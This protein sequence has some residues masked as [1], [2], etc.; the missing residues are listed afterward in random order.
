LK[1]ENLLTE[2]RDYSKA[3]SL[4]GAP[5]VPDV[6]KLQMRRNK[7]YTFTRTLDLG[8]I[9]MSPTGALGSYQV[10][11]S[12]FVG[13]VDFTGLF[14]QYRIIQLRFRFNP[15]LAVAGAQIYTAFDYD[16]AS[17]PS[18]Q[19]ELMQKETNQVNQGADYFERVLNPRPVLAAYGG[20]TF[21]SSA[22][23]SNMTWFD[24]ASSSV[25]YYGLKYA[26]PNFTGSPTSGNMFLVTCEAVIQTRGLK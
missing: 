13:N 23:V 5:A 1:V 12:S 2:I 15:T 10:A 18:S 25:P 17:T 4:Y 21:T 20:V 16:D 26:V 24:E 14:E 3:A 7:V 9:A 19:A 22:S 8:T 6:P 11:L